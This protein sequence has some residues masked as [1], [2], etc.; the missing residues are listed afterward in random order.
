MKATSPCK[1]QITS[2]HTAGFAALKT[3]N[4]LLYKELAKVR[5]QFG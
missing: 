2:W 3:G 5:L 4:F 1:M